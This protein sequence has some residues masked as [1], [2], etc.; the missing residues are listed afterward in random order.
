M[1][2][3]FVM[4]CVVGAVEIASSLSSS[5]STSNMEAVTQGTAPVLPPGL[6]AMIAPVVPP[7]LSASAPGR[8]KTRGLL[9]PVITV[10][11]NVPSSTLSRRRDASATGG[12]GTIGKTTLQLEMRDPISFF[13]A[14]E[15]ENA[16]VALSTAGGVLPSDI[17]LHLVGTKTILAVMQTDAALKVYGAFGA[18]KLVSISGFRL[19]SASISPFHLTS[20]PAVMRLTFVPTTSAPSVSQTPTM[21]PTPAPTESATEA[22]SRDTTV[23]PATMVGAATE[24]GKGS[25][26]APTVPPRRAIDAELVI[27]MIIGGIL[28]LTVLVIV[29]RNNFDVNLCRMEIELL[30]AKGCLKPKYPKQ[31]TDETVA[32]SSH[33]TAGHTLHDSAS[34]AQAPAPV[35]MHVLAHAAAELESTHR[36][37]PNAAATPHADLE[38]ASQ[39]QTSA[40]LRVPTKL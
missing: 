6:Q 33:G 28:T 17:E 5:I 36:S 23:Y 10:L 9:D 32:A 8:R 22:P 31:S 24:R 16:L 20:G 1:R 40:P 39:V 21:D 38:S 37:A 3:A 34:E 27:A 4:L 29:L 12:G 35:H 14:T 11:S 13:G 25:T 26:S 30:S 7:E 15:I 18:G 2:L 19:V